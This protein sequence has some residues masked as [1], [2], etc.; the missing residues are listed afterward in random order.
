[1]YVFVSVYSRSRVMG[2]VLLTGLLLWNSRDAIKST[3]KDWD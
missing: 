1:M 3:S 2:Q